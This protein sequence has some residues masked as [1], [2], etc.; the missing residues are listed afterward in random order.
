MNWRRPA[1]ATLA[2]ARRRTPTAHAARKQQQ[3]HLGHALI[4]F[5]PNIHPKSYLGC[6]WHLLAAHLLL[7]SATA[8]RSAH[9][10]ARALH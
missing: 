4:Q 2:A 5:H 10:Q 7:P 9:M 8:P 1:G 3:A 6:R